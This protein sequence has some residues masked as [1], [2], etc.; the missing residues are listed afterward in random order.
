[1]L[2]VRNP[3]LGIFLAAYSISVE[4]DTALTLGNENQQSNFEGL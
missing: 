1:M 2:S 4:A 3:A